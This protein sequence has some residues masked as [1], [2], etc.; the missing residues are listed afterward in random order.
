MKKPTLTRNIDS[1]LKEFASD[2]Y[3][4]L[5][6]CDFS[7]VGTV[8]YVK[9]PNDESYCKIPDELYQ[10]YSQDIN[11]VIKDKISVACFGQ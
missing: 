4:P 6:S 3:T 5:E 10:K 7:L 8:A 1:L 9:Y 2:N 11:S